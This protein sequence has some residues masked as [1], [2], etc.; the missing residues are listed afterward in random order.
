VLDKVEGVEVAAEAGFKVAKQDI[1][2]AKLG[3][4]I[5][6]FDAG[7]NNLMAATGSGR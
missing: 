2:L 6:L 7:H 1:D 5:G 3:Q 4:V